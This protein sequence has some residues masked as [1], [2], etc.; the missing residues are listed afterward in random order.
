MLERITDL[1]LKYGIKSLSMDDIAR[2]LGISKKT[3]YQH[4]SNKH[5]LVAQTIDFNLQSQN[6][7]MQPSKLDDDMNAIDVLLKVSR[8]IA[9][10][11]KNFNPAV[12]FDLEKYYP[13][14]WQKVVD[15]QRKHVY[16]KICQNMRQG[17]QAGLY[18]DDL[19][20]DVI[21]SI[22]VYRVGNLEVLDDVDVPF[23]E[24]MRDIFEYHI[25]GIATE[26]G[27][28][29]LESIKTFSDNK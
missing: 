26:K 29:Y 14:S 10:N 27:L 24:A 4:F 22:Y 20:V 17:I 3:L 19:N 18:R 8:V 6:R 16:Q 13:E 25:R 7:K 21:A 5:D 9:E 2:E 28:K 12:N 1:F 15:Y 23:Y 11:Q